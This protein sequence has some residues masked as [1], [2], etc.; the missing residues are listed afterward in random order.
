MS[1]SSGEDGPTRSRRRRSTSSSRTAYFLFISALPIELRE[2]D[3]P[4]PQPQTR[5]P[6][7]RRVSSLERSLDRLEVVDTDV[8]HPLRRACS[9]APLEGLAEPKARDADRARAVQH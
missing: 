3:E 5:P 9:H 4:R 8:R 7:P 2:P 1:T 6:K